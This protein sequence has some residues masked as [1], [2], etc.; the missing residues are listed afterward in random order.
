MVGRTLREVF[1]EIADQ[2]EAIMS[3]V[4]R[5][6]QPYRAVDLP[7][8]IRQAPEAPIEDAYFMFS[9][10]PLRLSGDH[11]AILVVAT[12]TTE[13]VRTRRQIEELARARQEYIERLDTLLRVSLAMLGETTVP[14]LLQATAGAAR[15]LGGAALAVSGH[16]FV[17][18]A[19]RVGAS[20]HAGA[21]APCPSGQ[22]FGVNR[23]GVHMDLI[24]GRESIRLTD[25]EMRRHPRWWGLPPDHGPL[26]G[27]LVR[28]WSTARATPMG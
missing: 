8:P 6:G 14:G 20:S 27:L 25:E 5:T 11:D 26:R 23:G 7:L 18:G 24:D 9:Y 17:G 19:F 1:P 4:M 12:E 13:A 2:I 15:E 21:Q 3:E 22:E 16:G 10:I 28:A